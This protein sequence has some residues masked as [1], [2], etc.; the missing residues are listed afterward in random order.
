VIRQINLPSLD[1]RLS[2]L[3][4]HDFRGVPVSRG[5][6]GLSPET[7]CETEA[8]AAIEQRS[9]RHA[10]TRADRR[11]ADALNNLIALAQCRGSRGKIYN[12][13]RCC[14]ESYQQ[15]GY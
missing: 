9:S 12:F 14:A 7:G 11:P 2:Y 1:S 10:P 13:P 3:A 5:I 4:R 15:R 8:R 6:G